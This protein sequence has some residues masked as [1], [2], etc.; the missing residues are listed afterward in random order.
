MIMSGSKMKLLFVSLIMVCGLSPLFAQSKNGSIVH[1]FP[2]LKDGK[3][4][5]IDKQGD[6]VIA[7]TFALVGK[8]S[9]GLISARFGSSSGGKDGYVNAKGEIVIPPEFDGSGDFSCGLASIITGDKYGYI[10]RKGKIVVKPQFEQ[11]NAFFEGL[12]RVRINGKYGYI[13]REGKLVIAAQFIKANDFHSGLAS[14]AVF[15]DELLKVGYINKKGVWVIPPK[16]IYGANFLDGLAV[17]AVEGNRTFLDSE[18]ILV[19]GEAK[20]EIIHLNGKVILVFGA[21]GVARSFSDELLAVKIKDKWG[22]LNMKGEFTITPQFDKAGSFPKESPVSNWTNRAIA[23][24]KMAKK[25][26]TSI[27]GFG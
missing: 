23:L 14:V 26:S 17:V 4:G 20:Y 19:F 7:P 12:A 24:T 22:Y 9:E 6:V 3:W 5:F 16:F 10:N 13:N 1:M 27:L 8:L 11:G 2:I 21:T 25:F 18:G 15:Q